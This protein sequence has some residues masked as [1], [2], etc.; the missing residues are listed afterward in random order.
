[1]SELEK[2]T[3]ETKELILQ[4]ESFESLHNKVNHLNAQ[5]LKYVY[6]AHVFGFTID[7]NHKFM[8]SFA[9]DIDFQEVIEY[10]N[11]K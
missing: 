7:M 5:E 10:L 11:L 9:K 2:M 3:K 8:K 1:M 6:F 4:I